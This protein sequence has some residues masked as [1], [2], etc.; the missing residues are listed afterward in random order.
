MGEKGMEE[1]GR[2]VWEER[3]KEE[4]GWAGEV[5]EGKRRGN[6]PATRRPMYRWQCHTYKEEE[7]AWHKRRNW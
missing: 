6:P 3:V 1:E 4:E 2:E 7:R 5:K